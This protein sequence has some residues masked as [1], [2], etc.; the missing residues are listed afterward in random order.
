MQCSN[1]NTK[2]DIIG[3]CYNPG[4]PRN[5]ANKLDRYISQL[6]NAN[7]SLT[8]CIQELV[9]ILQSRKGSIF[10]TGIGKSAHI[11]KKCV[12]TWQ[13]LGISAHSLLIQDMLHGDIGILK[14]EDTIIYASNSGNTDELLEV[15]RYVHENFSVSQICLT[16]NPSA[17]LS[18]YVNYSINICNFKIREAD[19]LDMAPSISCVM[20]MTVFDVVGIHL[21]EIGGITKQDFQ[22]CHP[23]GSLGKIK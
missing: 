20:F 15:S 14:P 3:I 22:R 10:L 17:C 1:C 18:K 11:M 9:R 4:C 5:T 23:G 6:S 19:I 12:A 2:C 13:S 21:A 8:S 16:N 7:E